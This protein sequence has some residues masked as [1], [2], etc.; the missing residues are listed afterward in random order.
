M[1]S[2]KHNKH[3]S[4]GWIKAAIAAVYA[5][6]VGVLLTAG[7]PSTCAV[8]LSGRL[9]SCYEATLVG[10]SIHYLT[11]LDRKA[12]KHRSAHTWGG[13]STQNAIARWNA[14]DDLLVCNNIITNRTKSDSVPCGDFGCLA[15]WPQ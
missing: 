11:V 4:D 9:A 6:R 3:Q 12:G 7:V 1:L 14:G 15:I 13:L 10:T 5:K 8:P 2:D